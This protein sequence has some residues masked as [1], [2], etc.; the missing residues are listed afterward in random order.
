MPEFVVAATEKRTGF[1]YPK[2]IVDASDEMAAR[3]LS[4]RRWL[5]IDAVCL[6]KEQPGEE[7]PRVLPWGPPAADRVFEQDYHN[8]PPDPE[9]AK[10]PS[11]E[12]LVTTGLGVLGALLRIFGT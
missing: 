7:K 4:Q 10:G 8:R 6:Y 2:F 12:E 9:T 3:R 5:E 1:P 11:S